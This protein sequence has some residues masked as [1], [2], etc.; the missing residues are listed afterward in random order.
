MNFR[1]HTVNQLEDAR[2]KRQ[3]SRK[4]IIGMFFKFINTRNVYIAARKEDH[5]QTIKL[6]IFILLQLVDELLNEV[7]E[8]IFVVLTHTRFCLPFK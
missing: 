1:A 7:C 3:N 4:R 8:N 6:F 5:S 2:Q